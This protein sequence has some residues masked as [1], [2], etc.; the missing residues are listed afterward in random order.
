MEKTIANY[1]D[2]HVFEEKKKRKSNTAAEI[3]NFKLY[4]CQAF[5]SANRGPPEKKVFFFSQENAG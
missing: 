4:R 1:F 2:F 3:G 5:F